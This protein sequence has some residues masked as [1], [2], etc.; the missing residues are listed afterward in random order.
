MLIRNFSWQLKLHYLNF[1]KLHSSF[2]SSQL[3][4]QEENILYYWGVV[5]FMFR[6]LSRQGK[7]KVEATVIKDQAVPNNVYNGHVVQ[8]LMATSHKK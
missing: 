6:M 1:L 7:L 3:Y 8:S 4:K 2:C 5:L